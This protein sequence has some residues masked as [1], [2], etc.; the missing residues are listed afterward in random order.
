M[1]KKLAKRSL[2][3]RLVDSHNVKEFV[4]RLIHRNW[5]D[6]D[7]DEFGLVTWNEMH[8]AGFERS[9]HVAAD[10]HVQFS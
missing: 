10:A 6:Q 3:A 7:N 8:C 9:P 2:D 1:I 4:H 5:G